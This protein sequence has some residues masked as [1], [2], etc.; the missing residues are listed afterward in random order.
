MKIFGTMMGC[1][2]AEITAADLNAALDALSG[3]GLEIREITP[4]DELT[5]QLTLSRRDYRQLGAI[6][7]KRG[8]GLRLIRRKGLYWAGKA[9]MRRPVLL[10]GMLLLLISALWI[11]RKVFF[12]RVEGNITIPTRLILEEAQK[13]GIGFGANR[14]EVRSERVKNALVEAVPGL[15]WAGVNTQG[16]VAVIQVRERSAEPKNS[17]TPEFGHIVA[18]RDGIITE[19]TATRGSLLCAP[20]QAVTEGEVLISGYTDCGLTIRAELAEGEVYALTRRELTVTIPPERQ[21]RTEKEEEG[22]KIDLLIG[23]KRINLWKDSGIWD[24]T[25]DRMYEEY[26][27]TLP[28]G[29]V[30]PMAVTVERYTRWKSVEETIPEEEAAEL[31]TDCGASYLQSQMLAGRILNGEQ[32]FLVGDDRTTMA[33]QY[34]CMEM[35]GKMRRLQI[36]E[37]NGKNH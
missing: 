37:D 14:R 22:K 30:L 32:H 35:I 20:G 27:I 17:Q 10:L 16:C 2:R 13:C 3:Q 1:V 12:L 18:V 29:F 19:C 28:G 23:K 25:C 9:L 24:S 31:L 7:A 34:I 33:G 8:D 6:C 5:A 26:Y 11:P 15:Q 21:L 4:V 36:G